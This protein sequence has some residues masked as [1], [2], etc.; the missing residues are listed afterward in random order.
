MSHA[1]TWRHMNRIKHRLITPK[2][3][4]QRTRG[5]DN[6]IS[7]N[8]CPNLSF[9]HLH[10]TPSFL[11]TPPTDTMLVTDKV[12]AH[13]CLVAPRRRGFEREINSKPATTS[14]AHARSPSCPRPTTGS[15]CRRTTDRTVFDYVENA[16]ASFFDFFLPRTPFPLC[17]VTARVELGDDRY[18]NKYGEARRGAKRTRLS[19]NDRGPPAVSTRNLQQANVLSVCRMST[20][21]RCVGTY[22]TMWVEPNCWVEELRP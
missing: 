15:R 3:R 18:I 4:V 14:T 12:R 10:S 13:A 7:H 1:Q 17:H 11:V 19:V 9:V 2:S 20:V 16:P 5:D 6:P 21:C 22:V 8:S